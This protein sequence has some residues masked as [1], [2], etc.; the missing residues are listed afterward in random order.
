MTVARNLPRHGTVQRYRIELATEGE[1]PCAPCRQANANRAADARAE[2]S[3][4]K[5]RGRMHVVDKPGDDATDEVTRPRPEG[6]GPVEQ[7]VQAD[8]D[9]I[10]ASERVRFHASLTQLA[11]AAA[12]EM[13]AATS[14]AARTAARKDAFDVLKALGAREGTDGKHDPLSIALDG[15]GFGAAL[16]GVSGGVPA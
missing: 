12:R 3:A 11:L 8:I 6:P 14:S 1:E 13:D 5:R 4:A 2:A 15:A 10:P 16:P 7:A 9:A